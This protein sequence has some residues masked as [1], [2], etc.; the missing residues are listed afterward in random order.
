MRVG[1]AY[2]TASSIGFA[3]DLFVLRRTGSGYRTHSTLWKS[4]AVRVA[5]AVN[6]LNTLLDN[7]HHLWPPTSD[8]QTQYTRQAQ[9]TLT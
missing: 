5:T 2:S 8:L 6:A 1:V 7:M 4:V 9:F 3:C